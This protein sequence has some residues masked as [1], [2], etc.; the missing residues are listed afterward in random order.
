MPK[1]YHTEGNRN[2]DLLPSDL[3]LDTQVVDVQNPLNKGGAFIFSIT[4][5]QGIRQIE[6]ATIVGTI[7]SAG[8]AEVIVTG[9]LVAGSPLATLVTVAL[10]D[11]ASL[12][13]GKIRAA[14]SALSAITDDYIVSGETDKVI[15][16][17]IT[18]ATNDATLNIDVHNSTSVGIVDDTTSDNTQAGTVSAVCDITPKIE[19]LDKL[20]NVVYPILIGVAIVAAGTTVLKVHPNLTIAAN[21]VANDLIPKHF[22]LTMTHG[23]ATLT[24]YSVV[25]NSNR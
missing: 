21:L 1:V 8:D 13:A 7:T 19:G 20:N 22:R 9:A 11:T 18:V 25:F 15:L 14:L 24:T 3:R 16:T 17:N 2:H 5:V 4:D 12:I 6:T 23:D 10:D